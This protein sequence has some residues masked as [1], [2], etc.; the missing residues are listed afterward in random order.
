MEKELDFP[1]GRSIDLR[2]LNSYTTDID[3]RVKDLTELVA[4]QESELVFLWFV[5]IVGLGYVIMKE[6]NGR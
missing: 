6:H 4:L 2:L 1:D 3:V 5:V